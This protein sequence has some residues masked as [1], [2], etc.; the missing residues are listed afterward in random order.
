[1]H[2]IMASGKILHTVKEDFTPNAGMY[3]SCLNIVKIKQLDFFEKR[4][5]KGY[6]SIDFGKINHSFIPAYQ[7][8][9][10]AKGGNNLRDRIG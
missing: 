3:S 4:I 8:L 2:I 10:R 5:E 9:G 7:K 6:K 1:M